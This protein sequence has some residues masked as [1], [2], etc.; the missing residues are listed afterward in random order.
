[1]LRALLLI[2]LLVAGGIATGWVVLGR[3]APVDLDADDA[4]EQLAGRCPELSLSDAGATITALRQAAS[5]DD[6]DG[7]VLTPSDATGP[8]A[9]AT[10]PARDCLA[11]ARITVRTADGDTWTLDRSII[12]RFADADEDRAQGFLR[13]VGGGII[14]ATREFWDA[15]R[16]R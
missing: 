2:G 4:A 7:L 10:G 8:L 15:V 14:D 1:M 6:V 12:D 11:S 13:I 5:T 16:N 9:D 3:D